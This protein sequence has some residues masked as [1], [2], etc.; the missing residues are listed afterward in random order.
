MFEEIIGEI[1]EVHDE[2]SLE[3][4]E[5]ICQDFYDTIPKKIKQETKIKR[6]R[7]YMRGEFE[8]GEVVKSEEVMVHNNKEY[9]LETLPKY[10]FEGKTKIASGLIN[11]IDVAIYI[12]GEALFMDANLKGNK[13]D[14]I[15][16]I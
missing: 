14:K 6:V 7:K 9:S 10:L 12:G 5:E 8:L 11:I 15:A 1:L 16:L 2:F 4:L 13:T 3:E